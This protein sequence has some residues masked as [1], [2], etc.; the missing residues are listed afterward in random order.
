MLP[1]FRP[2]SVTSAP[3]EEDFPSSSLAPL[4]SQQHQTLL[5][6]AIVGRPNVGK[7]TLFN[8]LT[9]SKQA[10]VTEV[11]GTTRDRKEAKGQLA[12]LEFNV[13]DTGGLDDRGA[14]S[15]DI[16]KHV[17][18]AVQRC[19]LIL[20]LID[21]KE[22]ITALD[23]HFATWLRKCK[24]KL[25]K[26]DERNRD[27]VC[28]VNKAEGATSDS[29]I[30]LNTVAEALELGFGD[31]L[32]ISAAHGDGMSDL[33]SLF[34]DTCDKRGLSSSRQ[35]KSKSTKEVSLNKNDNKATPIEDRVIQ[36][37]IMGRP[38]VGKSTLLNS[39]IGEERVIVGPTAGLTRDA[40]QVEWQHENRI[41]KLV[42]TAGLTRTRVKKENLRADRKN[43]EASNKIG[44]E[45]I[46]LPGIRAINKDDKIMYPDEDPSQFSHQ[47]SEFAQQSA[48]NSLKYAQVVLLVVEGEQGQFSKIDLQLARKILQ[49]GRAIVIAANKADILARKMGI[50]P[51][52]YREGVKEHCNKYLREFGEVPVFVCSALENKG[53]DVVLDAVKVTHDAWSTRINTWIL[54]TW[55]KDLMISF[56]PPRVN[57]KQLKVKYVTQ[58]KA[59]PPSFAFF[60]NGNKFPGYY[61]RFLRSKIQ[62]DFNL[63]GIPLRFV[64]RK[65]EGKEVKKDLLRQGAKS[66]RTKGHNLGKGVGII[67]RQK[68]GLGTYLKR[69]RF[70]KKRKIRKKDNKFA[71]RTGKLSHRKKNYG[72]PK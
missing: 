20:F 23:S 16:Q 26:E 50:S 41:F 70:E 43:A 53:V 64:V 60:C 55:L 28:V 40:I 38:N 1:N 14:I 68:G 48:L 71:K 42:D 52:E 37:S 51:E 47:I 4:R 24:S 21:G 13:I 8:R 69:K 5:S 29:S 22:G 57:D 6:V 67:R 35:L 33:A 31:P 34:L 12:E 2:S 49:E 11:P 10:I 44:Y 27:I 66:N 45:K 63:Q 25:M 39:M 54:N 59:R 46:V 7:S 58:L 3:A 15:V 72:A 61:E 9:K 36:L 32:L 65:S 17:N 18:I 62:E 30:V 19:H 56:P